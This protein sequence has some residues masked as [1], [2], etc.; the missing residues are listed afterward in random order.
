M[1]GLARWGRKEAEREGEQG[2]KRGHGREQQLTSPL[3][4]TVSIVTRSTSVALMDEE[5][6]TISSPACQLTGPL[7][8]IEASPTSAVAFSCV[9]TGCL[10]SPC[11]TTQPSRTASTL[12]P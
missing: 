6:T 10:C 8:T 5:V 7:T 11:M 12:F 2:R 1:R 3:S 9:Q 4:V